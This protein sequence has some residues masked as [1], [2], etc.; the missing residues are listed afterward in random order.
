[1]SYPAANS[2]RNPQHSP[3][4]PS[5]NSLP[6]R[7]LHLSLLDAPICVEIRVSS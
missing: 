3:H 2:I 4:K 7:T 5:R 6:Q 1:M